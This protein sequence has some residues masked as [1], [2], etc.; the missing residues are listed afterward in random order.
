MNMA[1]S[2]APTAGQMALA[3]ILADGGARRI[4]AITHVDAAA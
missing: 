3:A 4:D 1:T 2:I